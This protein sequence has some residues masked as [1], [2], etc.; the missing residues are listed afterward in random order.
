LS[1]EIITKGGSIVSE[2]PPLVQPTIY[3]FPKRN[4]IIA[5]LSRGT[6]V[7]EAPKKSGSLIT[8]DCALQYNREVM[9]VPQNITSPTAQG[10]NDLLKQGAHPITS[11]T[12]ILEIL[13]LQDLEDSATTPKKYP[14]SQH[15]RDLLSLLSTEPTHIDE[16]IRM[17][18]LSNT[19][20]MSTL[21]LMEM[22]GF[23]KHIGGMKYVIRY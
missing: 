22:N 10:T 17:S 3:S 6:V 16:L 14:S 1:E 20:I 13:Q 18:T 5:G 23:V 7:I 8:A 19:V 4:R 21:M 2:Y 15:E 12:D 11:Y 9:V